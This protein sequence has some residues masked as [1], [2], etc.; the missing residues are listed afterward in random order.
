MMGVKGS[1]YLQQCRA[2]KK[3][4]CWKAQLFR[5]GQV[6]YNVNLPQ[7]KSERERKKLNQLLIYSLPSSLNCSVVVMWHYEVIQDDKNRRGK[8][9]F[10]KLRCKLNTHHIMQDRKNDSF[11]HEISMIIGWYE[12]SQMNAANCII[13]RNFPSRRW[14]PRS[15]IL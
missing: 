2:V 1:S 14:K 12:I 11:G 10:T 3:I 6:T 9:I 8:S 4:N 7:I 15:E 13:F 5:N